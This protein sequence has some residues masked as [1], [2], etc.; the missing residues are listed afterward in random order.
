MKQSSFL[1]RIQAEQE[2]SNLQTMRFTRQNM[3]DVCMVALN[4]EFGFGEER[5]HRFAEKVQEVYC[6]YADIWNADTP[7]I[8][9][10]REKMDRV[11]KRIC[12]KNF[13]P[14]DKRYS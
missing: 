7:D 8:T 6:E 11:L 4:E 10:A 13:L 2:R 3:M 12:G 14:W 1:K 5:L 9:Y